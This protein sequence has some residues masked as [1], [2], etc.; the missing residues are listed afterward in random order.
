VFETDKKGKKKIVTHNVGT[1]F[2]IPVS[3]LGSK[4]FT[5]V[6]VI[7]RGGDSVKVLA[8][9]FLPGS[10]GPN[11]SDDLLKA[12]EGGLDKLR[13]ASKGLIEG[14]FRINE[15]ETFETPVIELYR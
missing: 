14:T 8:A 6:R 2:E 3:R 4:D 12:V 5:K 15:G 9:Y 13:S 1:I 11:T 7:H 10:K